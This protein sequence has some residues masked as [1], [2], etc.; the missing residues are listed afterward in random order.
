MLRLRSGVRHFGSVLPD[1]WGTVPAPV[2][3]C[4]SCHVLKDLSEFSIHRKSA[5]GRRRV[6]KLCVNHYDRLRRY[7][8]DQDGYEALLAAQ[9]HVCALCDE[10][11]ADDN[12]ACVDH[13]HSCCPGAPSCGRCV[14]GLICHRCNKAI[15]LL[16]DDLDLF[17]RA[18]EYL[19]RGVTSNYEQANECW[20]DSG[21][22]TGS[23]IREASPYD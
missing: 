5:D 20:S 6:C 11:F 23:G 12:V 8:L 21:A 13:D 1:G 22:S 19:K 16:E 14:R 10:P 2:R 4:N 17:E 3:E 9:C 15:G 7:G 18:V